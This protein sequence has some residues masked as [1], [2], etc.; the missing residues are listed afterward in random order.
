MS[1]YAK[2]YALNKILAGCIIGL[3][4]WNVYTTNQLSIEVAVLAS[5][6]EALE[7]QMKGN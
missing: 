4:S 2:E 1:D 7:E 6:V 5:K 3:L